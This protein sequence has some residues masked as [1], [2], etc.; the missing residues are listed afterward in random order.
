MTG[1]FAGV[2]QAT[3][4]F[5]GYGQGAQGYFKRFGAGLADGVDSTF[6]SGAIL[7]VLFHQDPR[8]FYKGTGSVAA[9]VLYA[10]EFVVRTRDDHG[11][12]RPNYS[13]LLG[14][15]GSGAISNA[16][17]PASN[18]HGAGLTFENA[19][20]GTAFGAVGNILEELFLK[21]VTPNLPSYQPDGSPG[22]A[23]GSGEN[24]SGSGGNS[25]GNPEN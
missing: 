10:A 5:S 13:L 24:T 23:N 14:N 22:S 6:L 3:N 4:A 16:Y 7:P 1:V 9:R 11:R 2:E 21:H 25:N 17:Y 20:I 19:V 12:W 15:L 8:Y 18:R